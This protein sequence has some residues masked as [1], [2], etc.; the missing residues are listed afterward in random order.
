MCMKLKKKK[1]MCN[2]FEKNLGLKECLKKFSWNYHILNTQKDFLSVV[3]SHNLV[4][5]DA[6][7]FKDL[8]FNFSGYKQFLNLVQ[9]GAMLTNISFSTSYFSKWKICFKI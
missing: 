3:R 4:A 8:I 5:S 1:E 2:H 9:C 7:A 6:E